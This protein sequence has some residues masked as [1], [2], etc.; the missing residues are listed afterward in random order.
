MPNTVLLQLLQC[1][2][3]ARRLLDVY[4][5]SSIKA[6]TSGFM[7]GFRWDK[8]YCGGFH[9]LGH[10]LDVLAHNSVVS[11]VILTSDFSIYAISSEFLDVIASYNYSDC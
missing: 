11:H 4:Y 7:D 6:I 10:I 2:N 1:N 5:I 3:A 8:V 9:N